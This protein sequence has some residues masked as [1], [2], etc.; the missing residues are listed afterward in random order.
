VKMTRAVRWKYIR[1]EIQ[2]KGIVRWGTVI[3]AKWLLDRA[4]RDGFGSVDAVVLTPGGCCASFDIQSTRWNCGI[5][6]GE[7]TIV[8]DP[9]MAGGN[10]S[11]WGHIHSA[12]HRIS[13]LVDE[14]Q[15]RDDAAHPPA[16]TEYPERPN[17][18]H[19]CGTE[20]IG[21]LCDACVVRC[22]AF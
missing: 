14:L 5:P 2:D 20:C 17:F 21:G 22:E 18:C 6:G 16:V 4:L 11:E 8:V 3:L 13:D 9:I 12:D 15:A 19:E 7:L 10:C 1:R